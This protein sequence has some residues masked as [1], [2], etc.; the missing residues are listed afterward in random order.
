M[1]NF[2]A[3]SNEYGEDKA[4]LLKWFVDED[5]GSKLNIIRYEVILLINSEV[6]D[7]SGTDSF[8]SA[9]ESNNAFF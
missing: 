6:G 3:K 2:K 1:I 9:I 5:I 4:A 7:G 8:K